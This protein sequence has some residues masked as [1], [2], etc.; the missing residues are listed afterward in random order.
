MEQ[1]LSRN[2]EESARRGSSTGQYGRYFSF[3]STVEEEKV[4]MEKI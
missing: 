4:I 2:A 3:E 1:G